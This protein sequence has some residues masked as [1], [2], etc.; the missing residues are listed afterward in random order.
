M[1]RV[2]TAVVLAPV[3]LAIV[4]FVPYPL[5]VVLL[6]ALALQTVRE[7][8]DLAAAAGA[9]AYRA[10]GF[11]ATAVLILGVDLFASASARLLTTL[12]AAIVVAVLVAAL[13]HAVRLEG[14]FADTGAT[15]TGIFYPGLAIA[16]VGLVRADLGPA[17]L[18]W[19]LLVVWA[20]DVAALYIGRRWGEQKLAARVSPNKTRVGAVAALIAAV[21]VGWIV[22]AIL[23]EL[24]D[25]SALAPLHQG[26]AMAWR[27]LLLA[28]VALV[29]S[30]AAQLGDLVESIFKRAAHS[31][32]S[33]GLLPGHGGV[34]DRVDALLLAAPVFWVVV[35]WLLRA[36]SGV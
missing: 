36:G 15:L 7:F 10:L 13:A 23:A 22:A 19:L 17:W 33:G 1:N 29:V 21:V 3:V 34:F 28:V 12:V 6:A 8:Y 20:G 31:K 24:L 26:W 5:F 30:V 35:L 16:T 2:L 27:W 14:A 18:A 9:H 32:D 25:W 11:A 4:F